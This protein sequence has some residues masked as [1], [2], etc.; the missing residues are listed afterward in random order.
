MNNLPLVSIV[1]PTFNSGDTIG[2]VLDSI[3]KQTYKKLELF[4]VDAGSTDETLTIAEKYKAFILK[5][6]KQHQ[7]Y[8]KHLGYLKAKGKYIMHLDSD[9]VLEN[10]DS[11]A[12][13]V[14]LFRQKR[15]KAVVSSGHKTPSGVSGV[16]KI[17]NDIGDPFSYYMYGFSFNYIF[18]INELK[19]KFMVVSEDYDSVTIDFGKSKNIPGIEMSASGIMLDRVY[20]KSEFSVVNKYPSLISQVFY[21]MVENGDLV[22]FTKNDPI[23]HYSASNF[24]KYLKKLRSRVLNNVFQTEMGKSAFSGRGKYYSSFFV[25]KKYLFI[26]YSFSF[27]LPFCEGLRLSAT[28]RAWVFLSYPYLCQFISYITLY[29]MARKALG[30]KPK[31]KGYGY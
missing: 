20:L 21:Y 8:A 28:R 25:L 7:V 29:Y 16:N 9:E 6:E 5:N 24:G 17:I 23:L 4:I 27:I 19:G 30:F 11:V 10:P 1:I 14:N 31:I 2:L 18:F 12:M 3:K 26:L 22:G 13:K 15:V